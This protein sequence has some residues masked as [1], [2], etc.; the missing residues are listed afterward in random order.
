MADRQ[1]KKIQKKKFNAFS[2]VLKFTAAGKKNSNNNRRLL[3][4]ICVLSFEK[5]ISVNF[6][7][8]LSSQ[9]STH[10]DQIYSETNKYSVLQSKK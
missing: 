3:L 8:F 1:Q 4:L 10:G 7:L 5:Q 6:F 9:A 2:L